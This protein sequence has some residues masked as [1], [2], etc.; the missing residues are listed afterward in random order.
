V[1]PVLRPIVWL[2]GALLATATLLACEGCRS[3]GVD[4]RG[5][6]SEV[7]RRPAA[8]CQ[9]GT[10]RV[11]A[12]GGR[13]PV[14][15]SAGPDGVALAF[16]RPTDGGA[17][18]LV[19][20]EL[21]DGFA[22]RAE[23]ALQAPTADPLL[24]EALARSRGGTVTA[25]GRPP[26]G[27]RAYLFSR[28]ASEPFTLLETPELGHLDR[29]VGVVLVP[30]P[31]GDGDIQVLTH[32]SGASEIEVGQLEGSRLVTRSLHVGLSTAP[33]AAVA[34]PSGGL[35]IVT[36]ERLDD[37]GRV[38]RLREANADGLSGP[39]IRLATP[40]EERRPEQLAIGFAGGRYEVA[41]LERS[42]LDATLHRASVDVQSL[43]VTLGAGVRPDT[44]DA[45]FSHLAL[46]TDEQRTWVAW[47]ESTPAGD[48]V[49]LRIEGG[50]A[51]QPQ[52]FRV[53]ERWAGRLV[54]LALGTSGRNAWIAWRELAEGE[55]DGDVLAVSVE[56]R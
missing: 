10:P 50:P 36:S 49:E 30:A 4:D 41:W 55:T 25:V 15:L 34:S 44:P 21:G 1:R 7:V 39:D 5:A 35:A 33:P 53:H 40:A 13:G 24:A 19:Y 20:V 38:L 9:P 2:L 26:A 3:Q 27:R 17:T 12:S 14:A 8:A 11:L 31:A 37:G 18:E 16:E 29:R 42:G 22:V 47:V 56:C 46:A 43:E 32:V 6:D 51:P 45:T 23:A 52:R 48:F 28:Q 54:G